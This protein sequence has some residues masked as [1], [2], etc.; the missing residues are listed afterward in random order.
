MAADDLVNYNGVS[1]R[2]DYAESLKVAQR[3]TKY[4]VDDRVIQRINFGG[5]TYPMITP[6]QWSVPMLFRGARPVS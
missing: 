2:R 3:K 1:M 4:R 5:E 6:R